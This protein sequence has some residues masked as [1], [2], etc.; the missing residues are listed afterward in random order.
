MR[1][2]G[3]KARISYLVTRI[4]RLA[5]RISYPGWHHRGPSIELC[6]AVHS[7]APGAKGE[8]RTRRC[9]RC[10]PVCGFSVFSQRALL[11]AARLER[12]Q[13]LV[14]AEAPDF[15]A[16]REFTE[17]AQE[18]TDVLLCRHLLT[19]KTTSETVPPEA[20]AQGASRVKRG[21]GPF[22][23]V[24]VPHQQHALDSRAAD[25]DC[26]LDGLRRRP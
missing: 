11:V 3:F 16:R 4:P 23:V 24:L 14:K 9:D 21:V 1:D 2:P 22:A 10:G 20:N 13:H 18:T 15:L 8:G 6:G 26:A 19:T 17:R 12:L 5:S 25:P 7:G